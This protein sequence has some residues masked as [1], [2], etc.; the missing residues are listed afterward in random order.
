[1]HTRSRSLTT[2]II[3]I[4]G[5]SALGASM[6]SDVEA[7]FLV[8]IAGIIAFTTLMVTGFIWQWGRLPAVETEMAT[9][10]KAKNNSRAEDLIELMDED[11][12]IELRQRLSILSPDSIYVGDDGELVQFNGRS[13]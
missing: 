10:E 7:P 8:A 6:Y 12:M 13:K 1:M 11:D 2:L 9:Y 4:F 3:W 5:M